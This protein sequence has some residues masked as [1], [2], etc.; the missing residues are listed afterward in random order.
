MECKFSKLKFGEIV[1][2]SGGESVCGKC[3]GDTQKQLE[4]TEWIYQG[5]SN[6]LDLFIP[7][8]NVYC[9]TCGKKI[10]AYGEV[11]GESGG[12]EITTEISTLFERLEK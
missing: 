5:H 10:D 8:K 4:S 12:L 1:G 6:E 11:C 7:V 9:P 3:A 2:L